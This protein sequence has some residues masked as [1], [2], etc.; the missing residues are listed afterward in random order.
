MP[1]YNDGMLERA[2]RFIFCEYCGGDKSWAR[3]DWFLDFGLYFCVNRRS[4]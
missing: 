1:R 2:K 3:K 4:T